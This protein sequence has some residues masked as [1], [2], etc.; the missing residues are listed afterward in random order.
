MPV[1]HKKAKN[2][3][4]PDSFSNLPDH[5]Q[6]SLRE[7]IGSAKDGLLALSI[8]VGLNVLKAMMEAE[9]AE[10]VG[11][12]GKHNPNRQAVRHGSEKGSVV[13]GGR[14]VAV[15]R[16]RVRTTDGREVRLNTY[17]AFQDERFITESVLERMIC[18]L[19]TRNYE[20]GLEPVGEEVPAQGISKST[21][22]RRFIH[23]TR[24]ALEELLSR[25]LGDKRFLVL[26]IDGVMFAG[27]TVVV[28]L[29]ITAEGKKEILGLWEG[30][31]ENATVCKSL[32][33]DLVARGLK[34]EEG[35][36][37]VIDGSKALR[38]AVREVFGERAVVQRCRV[39]KKRNVLEHLPGEARGWV[40]KKL[41]QA[42][43]EK[44]HRKA[45]SELNRLADTLEEKYPGAARSLREGLEETLTITRLGLPETLRKSLCSTNLIESAFDKVRVVTRNVKRW[46]SGMQVLR[47]AAAGLLQ[48]EKGFQRLKG[49]RE[50]PLLATALL[51]VITTPK[52]SMAVKTA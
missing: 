21:I 37:V 1:Y 46:R 41:N 50:L 43:A 44:D 27:H 18:G 30:A 9:V 34:A 2:P 36:L 13:P 51:E 8:T 38:L 40:G 45:L 24:K 42:W 10:I 5:V 7:A 35:I 48:A 19:S 14:K 6:V 25:P 3:I 49:Y 12:K 39:H 20:H 22:S 29:G 47:W 4:S 16:P 17:E 26:V 31:T 28:A 52:S 33:A 32:L 11:P 23:A 15:R